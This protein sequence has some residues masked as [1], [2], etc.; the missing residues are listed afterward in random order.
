MRC[1]VLG[2]VLYI[3]MCNYIALIENMLLV[4]SC[5]LPCV[6]TKLQ[7]LMNFNRLFIGT[8]ITIKNSIEFSTVILVTQ[9]NM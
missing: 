8:C 7:K 9:N 5:K 6:K 1:R 2:L 4:Y 3:G